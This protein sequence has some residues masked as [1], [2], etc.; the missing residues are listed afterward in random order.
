MDFS[1]CSISY[2]APEFKPYNRLWLITN[3]FFKLSPFVEAECTKKNVAPVPEYL[4]YWEYLLE[5][6]S[7]LGVAAP[8]VSF[9]GYFILRECILESNSELICGQIIANTDCVGRRLLKN[10]SARRSELRGK[11]RILTSPCAWNQLSCCKGSFFKTF[12]FF[13]FTKDFYLFIV[14]IIKIKLIKLFFHFW[15]ENWDIK[16]WFYIWN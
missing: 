11:S 9:S 16:V 13:I 4:E 15:F 2:L 10:L 6:R 14:M 5:Y 3:Y 7:T 1:N 8:D 12:L